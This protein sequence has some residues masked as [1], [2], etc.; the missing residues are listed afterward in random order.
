MLQTYED[1]LTLAAF[2]GKLGK[3]EF[4]RTQERV[5]LDGN[6]I[7][8]LSGI[9]W[10]EWSAVILGYDHG[11]IR[12]TDSMLLTITFNNG[13]I[14]GRCTE[15]ANAF[16]Q[17]LARPFRL[18]LLPLRDASRSVFACYIGPTCGFSYADCTF[19]EIQNLTLRY[20]GSMISDNSM[21]IYGIR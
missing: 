6:Q 21:D 15:Y 19:T 16:C 17:I 4:I 13:A 12:Q 9:D 20:N 11:T 8:D 14:S 5:N 10:N 1:K 18:I 3:I 2:N 7:F